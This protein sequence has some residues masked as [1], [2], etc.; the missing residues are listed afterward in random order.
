MKLYFYFFLLLITSKV[1]GQLTE[2]STNE[3]FSLLL[4]ESLGDKGFEHDY[5]LFIPQKTPK[6]SLIY[7]LV[8]PNNTGEISDSIQIHQ[9]SAIHLA[10]VRSVG[11]NISTELN[12]PL[13]VPI[14]PRPKSLPLVYTHA[15]DRDVMLNKTKALK[16]LDL[17]LLAMIKDAKLRLLSMGF[18]IQDK[19]LMNGFSASASFTNRFLFIHPERVKAA[20]M[21]GLNGELMLPLK[22]LNKNKLNYPLGVR[23]FKNRFKKSFDLENYQQVHQYI[24]MGDLDSNDAVQ[25]DDAYNNKERQIINTNL[26]KSVQTR[27]E[28]CQNLYIDNMINV[29]FKTYQNVGH[30]TTGK[31]NLATI[32]FFYGIIKP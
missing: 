31:M 8:E 13:L 7:L 28:K 29:D 14:F 26:G 21:G 15:I 4:I 1:F 9:E 22:K 12:I 19:I 23:D 17:Q 24:Y 25:F 32:L 11:N 20:A 10:S 18:I 5:L 27:W 2:V 16:R 3:K 30:W 6:D